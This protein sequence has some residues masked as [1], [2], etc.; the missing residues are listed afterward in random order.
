MLT[1][2]ADLTP[3]LWDPPLAGESQTKSASRCAAG[4]DGVLCLSYDWLYTSIS[5]WELQDTDEFA[6]RTGDGRAGR[7]LFQ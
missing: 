5:C 3:A 2:L 1:C 4:T 7:V 6:V